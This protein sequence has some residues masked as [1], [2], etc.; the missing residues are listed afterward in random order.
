MSMVEVNKVNA[1]V[2]ET[3]ADDVEIVCIEFYEN[4]QSIRGY[5][6]N[7]TWSAYKIR[8][9]QIRENNG[10]KFGLHDYKVTYLYLEV[11]EVYV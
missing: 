2:Q 7:K 10:V 5:I 9:Q 6:L 4:D 11:Y 8:L 3:T 1:P